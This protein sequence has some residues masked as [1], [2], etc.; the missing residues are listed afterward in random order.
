[1]INTPSTSIYSLY[2]ITNIINS[3]QYIGFTKQF[4]EKRFKQHCK[5]EKSVISKAIQ[6]YGQENFKFEVILQGLNKDD[7][8]YME[9]HFI[10]EYNTLSPNGYNLTTGG[11]HFEH[12]DETKLKMSKSALGRKVL[13]ETK[14]KISNSL[15]NK[16][17]NMD[18][19][20]RGK[21]GPMNGKYHS[22]KTKKIQSES[23]KLWW[24]NK[25]SNII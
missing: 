25:L 7:I 23:K 22:E 11:E 14:L 10:N 3:K 16:Y 24:A 4:P 8:L 2:S 17:T 15:K 21:I 13:N 18:H 9:I 5:F 19:P 12:T 6:K 20:Q 1:M